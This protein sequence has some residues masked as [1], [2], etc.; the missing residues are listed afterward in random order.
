M[1]HPCGTDGIYCRE[2]CGIIEDEILPALEKAGLM[3]VPKEPTNAMKT[4]GDNMGSS[5][6]VWRAMAEVALGEK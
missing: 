5:K 2:C 6:T 3:I 4:A 1:K